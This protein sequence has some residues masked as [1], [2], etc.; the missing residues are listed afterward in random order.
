MVHDIGDVFYLLFRPYKKKF[1]G[2]FFAPAGQIPQRWNLPYFL[3]EIFHRSNPDPTFD[4][5]LMGMALIH[6]II[7]TN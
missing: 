7:V 2:F 3:R 1:G 4:L 6:L 5:N